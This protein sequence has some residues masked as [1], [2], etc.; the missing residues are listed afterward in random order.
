[1]TINQFINKIEWEGG[2]VSAL[3]YGLKADDLADKNSELYARW[4]VLEQKWASFQKLIPGIES[5]L[6]EDAW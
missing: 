1:V 6:P 4:A 3:E 5:L 2:I